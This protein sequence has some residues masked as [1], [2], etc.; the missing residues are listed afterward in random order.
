ME[1]KAEDLVLT[2][3]TREIE[4]RELREE[5]AALKIQIDAMDF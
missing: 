1:A 2:I 3:K 4:N 5:I